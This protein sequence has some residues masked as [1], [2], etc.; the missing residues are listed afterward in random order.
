MDISYKAAASPRRW[1]LT[2]YLTL[3]SLIFLGILTQGFLIG[4]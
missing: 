3:T 2:V 4:A 1:A